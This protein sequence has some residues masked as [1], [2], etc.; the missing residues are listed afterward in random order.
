[1]S[2]R[3]LAMSLTALALGGAVAY[4]PTAAVSQST[5]GTATA[6]DIYYQ[7][8]DGSNPA[9]ITITA[10]S[11]VTIS[12]PSGAN[13]HSAHFTPAALPSAC[14]GTAGVVGPTASDATAPS[15]MSPGWSDSCTFNTVGVYRFYCDRHGSFDPSTGNVGGMSGTIT[16]VGT[17]T[18]TMGTTGT[19]GGTGPTGTVPYT[20]PGGASSGVSGST[21]ASPPA[22]PGSAHA[23]D[24]RAAARTLH[25]AAHQKGARVT[26]SLSSPGAGVRVEIDLLSGRT[27]VGRLVRTT[28]RASTVR[29]SIALSAKQARSLRRRHRMKVI[30][31]ASLSAAGAASGSAT[32]TVTLSA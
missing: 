13:M 23:L 26:G 31:R 18:G 11:A 32:R 14:T 1:M 10:G 12:Y 21:G 20:P 30:V 27:V 19:T 24:L 5:G 2:M 9:A 29:F 7:G 17:G 16:V 6:H 3:R 25:A 28:T 8:G 15:V 22:A 4:L